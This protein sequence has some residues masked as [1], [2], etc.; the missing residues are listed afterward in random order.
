MVDNTST[1]VRKV[2]GVRFTVDAKDS[3]STH[4]ENSHKTAELQWEQCCDNKCSFDLYF[5]ILKLSHSYTITMDVVFHQA[6]IELETI[7]DHQQIDGLQLLVTEF[8]QF[9][10]KNQIS[11]EV[12]VVINPETISGPFHRTFLLRETST[13]QQRSVTVNVRG[14]ILREGQGTATLRP[15][16]RMK[17]IIT[18]D[19]EDE[20]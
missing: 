5:G 12:E 10:S 17:S 6:P 18:K 4:E 7:L 2:G 14:K 20:E 13:A 3:S 16:V 8:P 11:F 1:H 15:E 19:K 9:H